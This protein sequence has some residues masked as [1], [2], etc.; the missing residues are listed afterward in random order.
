MYDI[1]PLI[2]KLYID[3][4]NCVV[5]NDQGNFCPIQHCAM[6]QRHII[7]NALKKINL[8]FKLGML[9]VHKALL[10]SINQRK[11][12]TQCPS[13][14]LFGD[15]AQLQRKAFVQFFHRVFVTAAGSPAF[16]TV[17]NHIVVFLHV[18]TCEVATSIGSLWVGTCVRTFSTSNTPHKDKTVRLPF[19]QSASG[20]RTLAQNIA[21][22]CVSHCNL[23]YA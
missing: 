6:F 15:E 17:A 7:D 19:D 13:W 8:Y 22:S 18:C 4:I 10:R 1:I 2:D 9:C 12:A 20:A 11:R 23:W 21:A 16:S 5:N 3:S 14:I